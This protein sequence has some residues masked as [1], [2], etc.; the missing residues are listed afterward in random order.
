[1]AL[2][3]VGSPDAPLLDRVKEQV[4]F[5]LL[6]RG[7]RTDEELDFF[8]RVYLGYDIP[9]HAICPHHVSPFSFIAD[10]FFERHRTVLGFA[11]RSGGKTLGTAILNVLEALFKPGVEIVSAGAIKKQ[12]EKG[13]E[14]VSQ[15]VFGSPLIA[16][17]VTRSLMSRTEF[18]NGSS[19]SIVTGSY[20][21]LNSPHPTKVRIDEIELMHPQ[22]L[23]EGLQMSVS[24]RDGKWKAGDCL[25]STRKFFTGT[26]QKILDEAEQ[27]G[28]VVKAWCIWEVL[29][30]CTRQCRGDPVYGDCPVY[31][32]INRDGIEE[33]LCGGRAHDLPPGGFFTIDDFIK[34]VSNLDAETFETQ[35]ENRRPHAGSLVY[36]KFFKDEPPYVVGTEEAQALLARARAEQW[37]RAVGIDFGSNFYAGYFMRDPR[38]TIWYQYEEYWYSAD[39]DLPLSEHAKNIKARDPLGWSSRTCVFADPAGR[40]A[41]RDLEEHLIFATPANNALY[42][43]VNHVKRLLMRRPDG[44]PGLRFFARCER[45]RKELGQL[46]VHRIGK[47]GQPMKDVIVKKDDHAADVLR[48]TT[49]SWET[50]GT[51]RY[52]MRRLRGVF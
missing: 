3:T 30:P 44:L 47:D 41:I 22:V 36:G 9:K 34:K 51:G 35:W 40:Q 38:T 48:Y 23:Q 5:V 27:R 16:G 52:K 31:S 17:L 6:E 28:V 32:R 8:I 25:T 20:H 45:M 33:P 18:L 49:F 46:Y 29:Q 4:F 12:A 21:G 26:M 43:G 15:M 10:Q 42:E 50:V 19:I 11:S 14:Y 13:Y 39:H 37:P 24:S 2:A 1:V 7:L